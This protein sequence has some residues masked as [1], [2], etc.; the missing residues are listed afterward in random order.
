[1]ND[2]VLNLYAITNAADLS[3][4]YRLV[5]IRGSYGEDDLADQNL[6]L[7]A[8]RVAIEERRPAAL[9]RMNGKPALAVPADLRLTKTE[10][11]LTPDVV[12]LRPRDEEQELSLGALTPETEGLGLAFLA[13]HLRNPLFH[14]PDLWS[15]SPWTYFEKCPANFR[16]NRREVDVYEGFSFRLIRFGGRLFLSIA[17]TN[18]YSDSRWLLDRYDAADL[19]RLKMRHLLYHTGHRWF[20]VQFLSVTGLNISEQKFVHEDQTTRTV[21]GHTM[22]AAGDNPPQWIQSLAPD[23]P[24]ITY[25]YPGSDKKHH[26]AA[27]LCKLLLSTDDEATRKL[28]RNSIVAPDARFRLTADILRRHFFGVKFDGAP[29]RFEDRALR[30]TAK[31]FPV[32]AQRFGQ[33]KVLNPA[34]VGLDK[35]G[36]VRMGYLLDPQ[37]GLAVHGPL[38]AQFIFMPDTL[39]R[40]VAQLFQESLENTMRSF[41]HS[42][43]QFR[44]VVYSNAKKR[45]LKDQVEAILEAAQKNEAMSGHGILVLP[46]NAAPDLHNYI[47]KRLHSQIQFQCVSAKKVRSF[48]KM[49]PANGKVFYEVDGG[50]ERNYTSYLRYTALGLIIVNRRWPWVLDLPTHYDAYIGVDVLRNTAAFTFFYEGGRKCF[51]RLEESPQREKVPRKKVFAVIYRYLK[52]DLQANSRPLRSLIFRRDG[53]AFSAEVLG[54]RDAVAKLLQEGVLPKE[55]KV[56]VMEV[57]KTFA[58]GLRLVAEGRDGLLNPQIGS[59]QELNQRDAILCT[60]GYP[61]RFDGTVKPLY[62]RLV[63]GDL[64]LAKVLEDTFAMS[65]LCWPVPNRCMRLPIDLKLCDDLLRATAGDADEEEAI[66]GEDDPSMGDETELEVPFSTTRVNP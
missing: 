64:E 48:H 17:L 60:T 34:E 36:T 18:K 44:S 33:G 12:E 21:Y 51:V 4:R 32:P 22:Q 49:V 20:P 7:L 42:P 25:Q 35:L 1:M 14:H 11:Q 45:T 19:S 56:G 3:V 59:W 43:Y 38:S 65:Q 58:P 5:D 15:G 2:H 41:L 9:V 24:A 63:L 52:E 8:K 62:L 66:Y 57:H 54:F 26:G 55:I 61:F 27:A 46:E 40:K 29:L 16:E 10:Y 31:C 13:F 6:S 28:H 23:S 37:G 39:D 47:K 53:R 30:T 50:Q